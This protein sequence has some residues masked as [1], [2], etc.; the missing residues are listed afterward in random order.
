MAKKK[1]NKQKR[2]ISEVIEISGV[3]EPGM[4]FNNRHPVWE[5][6]EIEGLSAMLEPD[7]NTLPSLT[8]GGIPSITPPLQPLAVIQNAPFTYPAKGPEVEIRYWPVISYLFKLTML[9]SVVRNLKTESQYL[10]ELR[11]GAIKWDKYT[12]YLSKI[13]YGAFR[14]S[15]LTRTL[16]RF[17]DGVCAF[18][19]NME[20]V[21]DYYFYLKENSTKAERKEI[22]RYNK[23]KKKERKA[24]D[25]QALADI[26]SL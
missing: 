8:G 4:N 12:L 20:R 7:M 22:K 6:I 1:K 21:K 25:K 11:T 23:L 17:S 14:Y 16:N 13:E 3:S 24:E 26:W 15:P 2:V 9:S 19:R 10:M 18:F 5:P